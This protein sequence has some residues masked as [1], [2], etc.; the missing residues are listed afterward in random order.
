MNITGLIRWLLSVFEI[1]LQAYVYMIAPI[2]AFY[3]LWK[4]YPELAESGR[5]FQSKLFING[6]YLIV[7]PVSLLP[8]LWYY[9]M[10]PEGFVPSVVLLIAMVAVPVYIEDAFEGWGIR[11]WQYLSRHKNQWEQHQK[12]YRGIAD[13]TPNNETAAEKEVRERR[14]HELQ[15]ARANSDDSNLSEREKE[16][17]NADFDKAIA[18]LQPQK[19]ASRTT[20]LNADNPASLVHQASMLIYNGKLDQAILNCNRAIALA[21]KIA[22]PYATRGR[23]YYDAR[24]LKKAA[25]DYRKAIKLEPDDSSHHVGL[26]RVFISKGKESK[27]RKSIDTALRHDPNYSKA[28]RLR[29]TLNTAAPSRDIASRVESANLDELL[30]L[31]EHIEKNDNAFHQDAELHATLCKLLRTAANDRSIEHGWCAVRIEEQNVTYWALL[32]TAYA[33]HDDEPEVWIETNADGIMLSDVIKKAELLEGKPVGTYKQRQKQNEIQDT[34]IFSDALLSMDSIAEQNIE[35]CK[36]LLEQN[37][38]IQA[39][40]HG[41]KL[42]KIDA[43]MLEHWALLW[44]SLEQIEP[45]SGTE[46][47]VGMPF[48]E[49]MTIEAITAKASRC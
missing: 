46:T 32:Y 42:L 35:C 7:L 19:T 38:G 39:A 25:R 15:I 14:L 26:A 36:M 43:N 47:I 11:L 16:I 8:F 49:S 6:F 2:V 29:E 22:Q 4:L 37:N 48:P 3:F 27:A 13:E 12:Q 44:L 40:K 18:D 20:G 33:V 24:D 23:A 17:Q 21:P 5:V 9:F 34:Q 30:W 41:K 28:L 31:S 1:V 45:G 10:P